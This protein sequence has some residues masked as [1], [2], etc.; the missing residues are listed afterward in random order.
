MNRGARRR[1]RS[2]RRRIPRC[3]HVH[4]RQNESR[5]RAPDGG[6]E[7]RNGRGLTFV[8]VVQAHVVSGRG[9]SGTGS[10]RNARHGERVVDVGE[11]EAWIERVPGLRGPRID[12]QIGRNR[13]AALRVVL[14]HDVPAERF[15]RLVVI[16]VDGRARGGP[17]DRHS[18][19]ERL[20]RLVLD[21]PSVVVGRPE[22]ARV[23]TSRLESKVGP[24][25][26]DRAGEPLLISPGREDHRV[27]RIGAP[28]GNAIQTWNRADGDESLSLER[29]SV[30]HRGVD[31]TARGRVRVRRRAGERGSLDRRDGHRPAPPTNADPARG[32]VA[33]SKG[34]LRPSAGLGKGKRDRCVRGTSRRVDRYR[35]CAVGHARPRFRE[36]DRSGVHPG[37]SGGSGCTVG[38]RDA[39]EHGQKE[40]RQRHERQKATAT[41]SRKEDGRRSLGHVESQRQEVSSWASPSTHV[42]RRR[43]ASVMLARA[44]RALSARP[45]ATTGLPGES[46][47]MQ[48][49]YA[50][51]YASHSF[52]GVGDAELRSASLDVCPPRQP[53]LSNP[54][55][56]MPASHAMVCLQTESR[57]LRCT[58]LNGI[59]SP[60]SLMGVAGPKGSSEAREARLALPL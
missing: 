6:H 60:S 20:A 53:T 56:A 15:G 49:R 22:E 11:V 46:R 39:R 25:R 13:A 24:A 48:A 10:R 3:G 23:A 54:S 43:V 12:D 37:L 36:S 19:L 29:E 30:L 45:A 42:A 17:A 9:E 40:R 58:V 44:R 2:R 18:Q 38:A 28:T 27:R 57:T 51:R 59:R 32:A 14:A 55:S 8:L 26:R 41:K 52:V 7:R 33:Q 21:E 35:T 31:R 50:A 4:V 5:R 1:V 34:G 16:P 47:P